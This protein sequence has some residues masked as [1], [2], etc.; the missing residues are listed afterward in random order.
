MDQSSELKDV[1]SRFYEA[2][3]RGDTAFVERHCSTDPSVRGIGTDPSEWWSGKRLIEVFKEQ[4]EAMGG[5]MPLFAGE[6]EAYSEGNVG[7]V[8]DQPRFRTPDGEMPVRFTGVFHKED[9]AWKLVQAHT[10]I[11]VS[12]EDTFGEGLPT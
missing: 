3:Q 2:L 1:M 12:N 6:I 8:A 9:G 5:T 4:L 11:G 7:W 10:S